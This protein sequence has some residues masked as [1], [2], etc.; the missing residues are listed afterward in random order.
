MNVGIFYRQS[1]EQSVKACA[2]LKNLLGENG[3]GYI[4]ITDNGEAVPTDIELMIVF[5]GDGSVL[6]ACQLALDKIPIVAINTGNVGFLTS[7]EASELNA[8]VSD[9]KNDELNFSERELLKVESN[10]NAYF[11]L[12]DAVVVKNYVDDLHS[13]CVKLQ[14]EIDGKFVDRYIADGLIFS[15]PTGSTAYA[16]SAGGPIITPNLKAL[17]VAPIC[18]HSLHS[19]PIVYSENSVASVKVLPDSKRCAL[20]VDGE[21]KTALSGDEKVTVKLA[22]IKLKICDNSDNFFSKLTQKITLWSL[23]DGIENE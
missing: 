15:T 4:E 16:L 22:D 14:L 3:I 7:Y 18:A 17:T 11:A 13:G 12:N 9:I 21:F 6:Q 5:G 8:L 1:N 20:Y 10:G 2:L 19:R 23:K